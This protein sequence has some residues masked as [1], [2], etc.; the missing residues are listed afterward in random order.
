MSRQ[1]A[2][3]GIFAE[4]RNKT[5]SLFD[6]SCNNTGSLIKKKIEK[7]CVVCEKTYTPVLGMEKRQKYCGATCRSQYHKRGMV[8]QF[9]PHMTPQYLASVSL[10]ELRHVCTRCKKE[11]NRSEFYLKEKCSKRTGLQIRISWC[12]E[13]MKENSS[14]WAVANKEKT[15]TKRLKRQYGITREDF[16]KMLKEQGG[17]CRICKKAG[18]HFRNGRP[19]PLNVDHN[20]ETGKVRG[21]LCINCNSGL[22]KFGDSVDSL[23]EAIKYLDETDGNI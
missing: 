4:I 2:N 23:K 13:C 14:K 16:N 8:K 11:K 18:Q 12:K 10:E 9:N 5:G 1:G 3:M 6:K 20:H 17:T 21:L 22:G 7:V 19:L 15:E